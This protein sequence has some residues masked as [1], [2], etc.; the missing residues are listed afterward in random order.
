MQRCFT[1]QRRLQRSLAQMTEGL[2]SCGTAVASMGCVSWSTRI[3]MSLHAR[4]RDGAQRPPICSVGRSHEAE[5]F[6]CNIQTCRQPPPCQW[7]NLYLD[8]SRSELEWHNLGWR[9]LSVS[10]L[11]SPQELPSLTQGRGICVCCLPRARWGL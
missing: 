11:S 8:T 7:V 4:S 5:I 6:T 10:L 9:V 2:H 3:W 1:N